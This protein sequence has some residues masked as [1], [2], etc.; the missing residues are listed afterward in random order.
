MPAILKH[1]KKK[2]HG[3]GI[4]DI[5]GI[6]SPIIPKVSPINKVI[7][8]TIKKSKEL[9]ELDDIKSA[10]KNKVNQKPK[11][12]PQSVKEKIRGSGFKKC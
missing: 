9:K 7:A 12:I 8:N 4:T 6:D 11:Q 3:E 2:F 10:N 5:I 1:E